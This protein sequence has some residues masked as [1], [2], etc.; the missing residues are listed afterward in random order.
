MPFF[1]RPFRKRQAE[2]Q[3]AF[4]LRFAAVLY[5]KRT[6]GKGTKP[7]ASLARFYSFSTLDFKTG[8]MPGK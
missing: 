8:V 6:G 5:R 3:A 2:G 1:G 7:F 4:G